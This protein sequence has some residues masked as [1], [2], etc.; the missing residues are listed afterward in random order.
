MVVE[1]DDPTRGTYRTVGCPVKLS[2][3]PADIT[4][5][6]LLGE[7]TDE[8]LSSLCGVDRDELYRLRA[9]GVVW[10]EI[11]SSLGRADGIHRSWRRRLSQSPS[12]PVFLAEGMRGDLTDRGRSWSPSASLGGITPTQPAP[13]E[14][15]GRLTFR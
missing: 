12:P 2:D 6:A 15:A 13:I 5:P 14:G 3:S 4:R 1:G 8:L 7:H 10:P 9:D 11:L